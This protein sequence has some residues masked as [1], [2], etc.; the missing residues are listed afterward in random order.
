[1]VIIFDIIERISNVRACGSCRRQD[2]EAVGI[3][4]ASAINAVY[5]NGM[6]CRSYNLRQ[7]QGTGECDTLRCKPVIMIIIEKV[8][9]IFIALQNAC[10]VRLLPDLPVF[11]F[12]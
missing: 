11:D 1:M 5:F 9:W 12:M 7:V 8:R 3:S 2:N 4:G 6:I 10:I